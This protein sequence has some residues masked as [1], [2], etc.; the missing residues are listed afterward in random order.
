M[1]KS[2]IANLIKEGALVKSVISNITQLECKVYLLPTAGK[3]KHRAI[4][5][6]GV[7]DEMELY[8]PRKATLPLSEYLSLFLSLLQM[9]VEA[10]ERRVSL[11]PPWTRRRVPRRPPS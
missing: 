7:V 2:N 9:S 3:T 5:T 10:V 11:R 6:T 8:S 1:Y 4:F